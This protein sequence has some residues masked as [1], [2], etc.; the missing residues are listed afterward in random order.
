[1]LN[2]V[3]YYLFNKDNPNIT[4]T[5]LET[6]LDNLNNLLKYDFTINEFFIN[7][8]PD[9]NIL[10]LTGDTTDGKSVD[11]IKLSAMHELIFMEFIVKL[12]ADKNTHIEALKTQF[13]ESISVPAN[14]KNKPKKVEKYIEQRTKAIESTIKEVFNLFSNF[15]LEF[16]SAVN[17]LFFYNLEIRDNTVKKI[18]KNVFDGPE[19]SYLN[20][21]PEEIK[22]KLMK[23]GVEDYTLTMRE[24]SKLDNTIVRN[25]KLFTKYKSD[26]IINISSALEAETETKNETTELA[27][28]YP[29]F[30]Q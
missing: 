12:N 9:N 2:P 25:L 28:L 16:D 14:I 29:E 27:Q 26:P 15:V 5:D 24:T 4:G 30:Y 8:L 21:A 1:M 10:A 7:A 19:N 18:N 6:I 23:G 17:D 11:L 20:L 22:K 3:N 13:L